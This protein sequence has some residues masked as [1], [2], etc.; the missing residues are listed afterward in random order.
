MIA[1]AESESAQ[2]PEGGDSLYITV[3]E[4]PKRSG[5]TTLNATNGAWVLQSVY[6]V[7]WAMGWQVVAERARSA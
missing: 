1:A 3:D 2:P 4:K 6:R 5:G 7:D